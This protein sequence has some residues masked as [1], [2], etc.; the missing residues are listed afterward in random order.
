MHGDKETAEDGSSR[1][2]IY[3]RASG[4]DALVKDVRIN[5]ADGTVEAMLDHESHFSVPSKR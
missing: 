5:S 1:A 2:V 4:K 3:L